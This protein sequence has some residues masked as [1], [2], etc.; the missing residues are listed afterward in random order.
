MSVIF[1]DK[2]LQYFDSGEIEINI[3]HDIINKNIFIFHKISKSINDSVFTVLLI[4]LKCRDLGAQSLSLILPYLPY[5]RSERSSLQYIYQLFKSVEIQQIITAD[6]HSN[7]PDIP[8]QSINI[9]SNIIRECEIDMNGK[10]IVSPDK[11]GY[12]RAKKVAD[13]FKCEFTCMEKIRSAKG[14]SHKLQYDVAN[15][16]ILII[17]DIIDTGN[18]VMSAANLLMT[19]GARAI[20]VVA[21]HLIT[22]R[23]LDGITGVYVSNSIQHKS[24]PHQYRVVNIDKI[25][26]EYVS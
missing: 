7:T 8:T 20:E 4:A 16:D 15:K 26:L 22:S 18:T 14:V 23:E 25:F 5:S 10:V 13:E 6:I 1:S 11:G 12:M 17:D 24:L 2:I 3:N 21:T 19:M 9:A